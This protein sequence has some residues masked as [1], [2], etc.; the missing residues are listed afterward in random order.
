MALSATD[1][2]VCL[3]KTRSDVMTCIQDTPTNK[4]LHRHNDFFAEGHAKISFISAL[5]EG[6]DRMAAK[7]A[8]DQNIDLSVVL[9]FEAMA[10]EEDF[11]GDVSRSEYGSR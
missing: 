9:P 2:T 3:K 5:A 8:I 10:Y 1:L 4:A 6:A 7:A 11:D